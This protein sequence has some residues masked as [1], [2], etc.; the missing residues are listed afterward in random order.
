MLHTVVLEWL[1]YGNTAYTYAYYTLAA[2]TIYVICSALIRVFVA[3]SRAVQWMV[4]R[5]P[6]AESPKRSSAASEALLIH[7]SLENIVLEL[8]ILNAHLRSMSR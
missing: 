1:R 5:E 6:P 8:R 3:V 2:Y 4:C 7:Q